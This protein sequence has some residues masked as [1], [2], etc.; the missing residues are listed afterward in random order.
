MKAISLALLAVLTGAS[1]AFADGDAVAGKKVFAKC[2]A[3]HDATGDKDK[4]G[5]NLATVVGRPAG[6]LESFAKK[7]SK[8]MIAAG[9]AG[10]VW[11]DAALAEYLAS[12]K[13]KI[14]GGS[15]A[16]VGLKKDDEIAN[17]IA[18]LKADPKP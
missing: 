3:C 6:S 18:Y 13:A 12:P 10:L 5:P 17:V 8:P 2:R 14:P 9:E 15:M 7:Y 11:D 16:F 4:I 1:A